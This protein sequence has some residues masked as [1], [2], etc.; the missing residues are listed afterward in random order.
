MSLKFSHKFPRLKVIKDRA[1]F[2][3]EYVAGKYVLHGGCVDAGL[4]D[5][6]R[7]SK[8]LLHD[9][10]GQTARRL[11]GVDVD[12]PGVDKMIQ[13]GYKDIYHADLEHWDYQ[14]KFDV[15]VLGEI[16]E[17]IDNCGDFLLSVKKFCRPDTEVIFTTPNNYYFLFWIYALLGKESIHP[18]HNYLFSFYSIKS[19][20][21]KFGF[22]VRENLVLWE[23]VDFTRVGD[24]FGKR[25]LKRM[26]GGLLNIFLLLKYIVPQYGK[27]IIVVAVAGKSGQ[28]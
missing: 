3:K 20:L 15:I 17:H 6:R 18:D 28:S 12:K 9:I 27:G 21:G 7:E 8:L 26:A 4:L 16:I 13:Q 1:E 24:T 5:E 25:L 14:D 2:L 10:L 11:V 22:D 23:K 19:L